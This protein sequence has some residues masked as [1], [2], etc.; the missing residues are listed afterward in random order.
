MRPG[1]KTPAVSELMSAIIVIAGM[2]VAGGI[3]YGIFSERSG[4]TE[5][6]IDDT[7]T[8]SMAR[9]S[10]L[11]ATSNVECSGTELQFFIHNYSDDQ[12]LEIDKV[13]WH[14]VRHGMI[15]NGTDTVDPSKVV[16]AYFDKHVATPGA[17]FYN[18]TSMLVKISDFDCNSKEVMMITPAKE[19]ITISP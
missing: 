18:Q 2:A 9:A 19:F 10:E 16:W 7:I 13:V 11:L 8:R 3:L 14:G 12:N 15:L 5:D 6:A 17:K 4:D 1:N